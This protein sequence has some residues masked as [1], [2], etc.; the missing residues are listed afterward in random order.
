[1]ALFEKEEIIKIGMKR[2]ISGGEDRFDLHVDVTDYD[3]AHRF[4]SRYTSHEV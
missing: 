2:Y 1:L 4:L 3:S